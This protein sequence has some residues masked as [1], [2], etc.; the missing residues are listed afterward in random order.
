MC[1]ELEVM[2]DAMTASREEIEAK[3]K[4]LKNYAYDHGIIT[5]TTKNAIEM[6]KQGG[7][8]GTAMNGALQDDSGVGLGFHTKPHVYSSFVGNDAQLMAAYG[9]VE[10]SDVITDAFAQPSS[11]IISIGGGKFLMTFLDDTMTRDNMMAATL[12]WTMETEKTAETRI[13]ICSLY[14]RQ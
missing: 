1:R 9:I 10:R 2:V 4:E 8:V 3:T 11:K 14:E 13:V 6:N 5:W 12:K 7:L